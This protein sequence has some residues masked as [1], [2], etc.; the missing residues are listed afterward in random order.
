[1][2]MRT[3]KILITALLFFIILPLQ[4]F[5]DQNRRALVVGNDAYQDAPLQNPVN[6]A[7]SLSAV[8]RDLGFSV[9]TKINVTQQEL[10]DAIRAF[11]RSLYPGDIGLFY[12]SGH[13]MQIDGVNYLLPV[14]APIERVHEIKYKAVNSQM[15]LE[16]MVH[17]RSSLNIIILDA[18]RN[19]PFKGDFRAIRRGLATMSA[20]TGPEGGSLIAYATAPDTVA[21][22]GEGKN[23]PYARHLMETMRIPGLEI[24]QVFRRVRVAVK[25]ETNNQQI[26]WESSSMD[27][28]FFFKQASVPL[29]PREPE[30]VARP[31]I[32]API[33]TSTGMHARP[34]IS[35]IQQTPTPTPTRIP[36]GNWVVIL[37]SFPK[38]QPD[39][40]EQRAHLCQ[41]S[42]YKARIIETDDYPNLTP[43]LLAVV[44]GPYS[45]DQA[46]EMRNRTRSIVR[47]AYIKEWK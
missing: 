38:M 21:R 36:E 9:T 3:K 34:Q 44:L 40:A 6:D 5:S 39:R 22:D 30:P 26:P 18:C 37:G 17:A 16:E 14:G 11:G 24:H 12:F 13:G 8:L 42:G 10:E 33:S 28:D 29:P 45:R 1:M 46:L 27:R 19:N 25:A 15:I 23:S 35:T 43:G 41:E 32:P 7:R 2:I 47:D 31:Q 4:S 20:P